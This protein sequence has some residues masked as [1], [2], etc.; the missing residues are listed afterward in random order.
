MFRRAR[1]SLDPNKVTSSPKVWSLLKLRKPRAADSSSRLHK[2]G[3]GAKKVRRGGFGRTHRYMKEFFRDAP[4]GKLHRFIWWLHPRRQYR[5]WFNSEGAILFSK[6]AAFGF[7]VLLLFMGL[8][9]A[10]YARELPKTGEF[11]FDTQATKF[12]DRSGAVLLYSVYGDENRSVVEFDK[13]SEPAKFAAVAI[14]DKNFYKHQGLSLTGLLRASINNLLGKRTQGGSTITQ[15]FVKNALL[16][17]ER[18][19]ERKIK[20]AIL[21]LEMERLYTKDEILGFYLNEIPYGGTA[22]GIEAAAQ[23]FFSKP[24]LELT[25]EESA[26]LAALPQA[27]T[28]YSPYGE[29]VDDL[30]G[31]THYIIGLMQEQGY[32]TAEEAEAAKAVDFLAKINKN[33]KAYRNIQAPYLVLEAQRRLEERYGAQT[34]ATAGWKII[35]TVDMDLQAKAEAA[36]AKNIGA[37]IRDGGDTAAV[38]ASDPLTGQVLAAVGGRDF[39][40]PEFGRYNAAFTALRQPGSSIKPYTYATL[41]KG[42]YGAGSILY[43]L[44]TDF[45]GNYV[46][47]NSDNRTKG[48]MPVR[49]A[50]AES[51]N[52]TAVKALYIA[53]LE[54]VMNTWR[55]VGLVS[56]DLDPAKHGLAFGLGTAELKLAEH[57]NG[58][59]SFANG[60]MHHSQAL[61]T[62]ITN[63][64]NQVVDEWTDDGKRVMD[65]QVAYIIANTLSDVGAK[66][67]LLGRL[68]RL[69]DFPGV[70]VATKTGT[71]QS[72][73]DAWT[74]GSATCLSAGVWVGHHANLPMEKYSILMAGPLFNDFMSEAL[75]GR[76]CKN[77]ERPAGVK[78]VTLD[79]YTGRAP[80]EATGGNRVTDIFPAW[81]TAPDSS[82]TE[83]FTIDIV[84]GKLATDCTPAGAKREVVVGGIDAEIPPGDPSYGRWSPPVKAY[85]A[86]LGRQGGISA[87]P[88]END[89]AHS[90]SDAQPK[91]TNFN[92]TPQPDGQYK[93]EATIM[94]GKFP[95]KQLDFKVDGQIIAGGAV[96][97]S[98]NGTYSVTAPASGTTASVVLTDEGYYQVQEDK[99]LPA[100]LGAE[101]M[102]LSYEGISGSFH[103]FKWSNYLGASSYQFCFGPITPSTCVS[104]GNNRKYETLP[105]GASGVAKAKSNNGGES[106]QVSY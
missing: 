4:P 88:T 26:M 34:V 39:N 44:R 95:L 2:L 41:M 83:K 40:E 79:R 90:C 65:E 104:T 68:G 12:Y 7:A 105:S 50:L 14:E 101:T 8:I 78:E 99:A 97:V 81:Y 3:G 72:R 64:Q 42:N 43:D 103:K 96:S 69:L 31:R 54:N 15:Q 86:S 28:Y 70:Q 13:I 59:E 9:Y 49:A 93:F 57:V 35:T 25:I 77:F 36:V 85:A 53:G 71:T 66:Q 100:V 60:G 67:P 37:I 52:L 29:N 47:E 30:I 56:S 24:A 33:F 6:V 80:D 98:T 18:S 19:F 22:Y 5:F 17:N 32:I 82:G 74:M 1:K 21:A 87:K 106:N 16:T 63:A 94:Q 27:P 51:R 46:P 38:V 102:S 58:Y 84:S 73:R 23:S 91:I 75:K 48:A 11:R 55:D 92:I 20:E 76:E 45:G 10:Y 62:K 61:W 89:D